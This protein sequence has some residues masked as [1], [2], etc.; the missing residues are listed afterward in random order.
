MDNERD[1]VLLVDRQKKEDYP[2]HHLG[3]LKEAMELAV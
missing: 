3:I 2:C 1:R